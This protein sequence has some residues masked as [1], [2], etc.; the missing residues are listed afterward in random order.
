MKS[1]F[2]FGHSDCPQ[3][4]LSKIIAAI[5]DLYINYG[6]RLFYV[7]NRGSFD[8][9]TASALRQC[10]RQYPEIELYLLIAYHPAEREI[11]LPENFD[12]SF[13]PPLQNVP[14]PYRIV[15]A[16]QYMVDH[17]DHIICYVSHIGNARELLV[18]AR[19]KIDAGRIINISE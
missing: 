7:G 1:C 15:R 11:I 10:K 5:E 14:K 8:R 12:G 16:N 17:V 18:Y 3:D 19:R 4:M 2:L 13:Y 9:L 6:I